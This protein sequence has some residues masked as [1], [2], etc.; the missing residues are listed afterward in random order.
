MNEEL[1]PTM[2]P[3]SAMEEPVQ[4]MCGEYRPS[5]QEALREYEINIRFLSRGCVVR[6]GCKEIPFE[7]F[8][9]AMAEINEY[10]M[11]DTYEV[12]KK[13]RKLLD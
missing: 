13:W 8:S 7:D 9:R 4:K 12:Q 1:E 10:V 5:K 2:E 3:M 6:I 11:G